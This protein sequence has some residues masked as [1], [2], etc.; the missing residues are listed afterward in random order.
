M[1]V[2][3]DG[4]TKVGDKTNPTGKWTV[5]RFRGGEFDDVSV[6]DSFPPEEPEKASK[7]Y[8]K[9]VKD[10]KRGAAWL[11]APDGRIDAMLFIRSH[12]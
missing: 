2:K 3:L 10:V 5:Y 12:G 1:G 4:W 9:T 8:E 6:V 7:L 11:V